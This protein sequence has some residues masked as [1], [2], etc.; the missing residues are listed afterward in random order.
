M[1]ERENGRERKG[2]SLEREKGGK[3]HGERREERG[4]R[5]LELLLLLI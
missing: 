3:G 5:V 4:E 2:G 1:V